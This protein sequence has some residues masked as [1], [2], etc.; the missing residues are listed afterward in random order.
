MPG[1]SGQ[2]I[3]RRRALR[4]GGAGTAGLAGLWLAACGGDSSKETSQATVGAAAAQAGR[5]GAQVAGTV[6]A[7]AEQA[8]PGGKFTHAFAQGITVLDPHIERIAYHLEVWNKLIKTP[9]D[10]K[11]TNDLTTGYEQPDPQTY[12]FK[13]PASVPFHDM[14]P[15]NGR[16]MTAEDVAYSF[17]RMV[18]PHPEFQ[19]K[20]YFD[21]MKSIEAVDPQTVKL[22][23]DGPFAPQ[24]GYVG[25]THAV[26]VP[27][28][29]VEK[30]G[31][32]REHAIGTGPF[33]MTAFQPQ[34]SYSFKKHPKYFKQGLPYLD[35][36]E[37]LR[38]AD[39]ATSI[40][41]FR[42]KQLD[43]VSTNG[44]DAQQLRGA[45]F[46]EFESDGG[47]LQLRP[48]V[49]KAPFS[50]P[51]VRRAL[52]LIIDRKQII[53]LNLSGAGYV[54][55]DLPRY[56]PAALQ[57]DELLKMPGFRQNKAEDHAEAKKLLEAAGVGRG[58]SFE[59]ISYTT[60][61]PDIAEILRTQF[62]PF[63]IQITN[64]PMQFSEWT[65][66]VLEDKFDAMLTG[67]SQRDEADE[68]YYA[69]Y[70]TK[71]ARNDTNLSDPK[72]DQMCEAQQKEI[73]PEK[74]NQLLRDLSLALLEQP[75]WIP[76]YTSLAYD[77]EQPQIRGLSRGAISY[78]QFL[79]EG[80][81]R[82][83]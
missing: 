43:W 12:V 14:D 38:I 25:A 55:A 32:L 73:N 9:A 66:L 56:F 72:I 18:T 52:H 48:N 54:Y 62:Q 80:T 16:S 11:L 76:L 23:T 8:R 22:V 2:R 28:E 74:R 42:S 20:Y 58:F 33:M 79:L 34:V 82:T 21:R 30:W 31:D 46:Q 59:T 19:K 29:A 35:E 17:K 7:T 64:R 10:G 47:S 6:A 63:G 13:L 68:Y 61:A 1:R 49:A 39:T 45:G 70:H 37:L 81:W 44:R 53:D 65:T 78:W 71:G 3:S 40:S 83:S 67:S 77:F 50:D 15:V 24:L 41:R 4:W 26:V 75:A 5:A 36:V 60:D 57:P 51:R 69:V 27:R